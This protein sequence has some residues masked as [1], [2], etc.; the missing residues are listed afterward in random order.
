MP[1]N[2]TLLLA[3]LLMS[4]IFIQAGWGKLLGYSARVAYFT[5]LG[6]PFPPGAWAVAVAMELGGGLLI[7]SGYRTR[8][9]A[10]LMALFCVVTA[11]IAHYHPD[12]PNQMIHFMKNI[13]MAGGFLALAA[14]G[15]GKF[16]IGR[17]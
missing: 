6:L 9:V 14:A 4:A 16:S 12:D 10:P 5:K 8:L 15:P 17:S 7:L 13:C 2:L 1:Q 11:L 3:R